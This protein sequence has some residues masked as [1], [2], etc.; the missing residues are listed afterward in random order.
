MTL[1]ASGTI[2]LEQ[3]ADEFSLAH[4]SVFPTDFYGKGGAPASGAL[5]FSDFYGRSAA[6]DISASPASLYGYGSSS[7][8][9]AGPTVVSVSGGTPPY[10]Y[11]WALSLGDAA[12]I[13][14]SPTAASTSFRATVPPA[15]DYL[16]TYTCTVTDSS[17]TPIVGTVDVDV[18]I[19][20]F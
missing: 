9:Y 18:S 5:A 4:N 12:I 19:S 16:A 15:T 7:P 17:G 10:T 1:P 11:S 6:L 20:R 8:V 13:V 14:L 2:T 3:I